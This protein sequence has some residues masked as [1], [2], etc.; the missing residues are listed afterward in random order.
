[1]IAMQLAQ[2]LRFAS[3]GAQVRKQNLFFHADVPQQPCTK[4]LVRVE[5]AR[6]SLRQQRVEPLVIAREKRVQFTAHNGIMTK[7]MALACAAPYRDIH[8]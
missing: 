7:V 1:M 5:I 8:E 4:F 2:E 3:A 6:S